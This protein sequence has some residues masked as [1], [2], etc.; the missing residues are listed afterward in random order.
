M[1]RRPG[2]G[3]GQSVGSGGEE[4]RGE[5]KI[6]YQGKPGIPIIRKSVR[7]GPGDN[8]RVPSF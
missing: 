5:G 2:A 8:G 1:R 7:V 3:L 6:S 4:R